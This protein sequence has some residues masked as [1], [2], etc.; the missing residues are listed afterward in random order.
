MRLG[1]IGTGHMGNPMVRQLLRAGHD[2]IVHDKRQ[3][4]TANLIELG[5]SWADSPAAAS[6]DVEIVF[7]SLPGPAEVDVAVLGAD[8]ILEGAT[9]GAVHVDLTSN[10]PASVRRLANLEAARGVTFLEAPVS[11]MVSGA[12]GA[13]QARLTVFAGGDAAVLECVRPL[14]AT[15]AS[16][17]FH[18]GDVGTGNVVKLTNNMI[19]LGSRVLIQEALAVGVKAG[20][21]KAKLHEMWDVSSAS[22]WVKDLPRFFEM[23]SEAGAPTFTLA[24]SAKDVGECLALSRELGVPMT[25]GSAVSQ[26]FT[27]TVARGLGNHGPAATLLT[28]EAEAGV[29]LRNKP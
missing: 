24:L 18:T 11:D 20:I 23:S 27:R 5:A 26:V 8:G 25:V 14:L 12:V 10:S 17:I 28:I 19:S 13:E 16:N 7:T 22:Q 15:F 6:A 3:E 21:D 29:K 2:L 1:F 9:D 4:T